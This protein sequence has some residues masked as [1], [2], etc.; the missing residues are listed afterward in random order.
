VEEVKV[1]KEEAE[2]GED[3]RVVVG[4]QAETT[5]LAVDDDSQATTEVV[6]WAV[7]EKAVVV[8]TVPPRAVAEAKVED[9]MAA[10]MA[11]AATAEEVAGTVVAARAKVAV[12][13]GAEAVEAR[14]VTMWVVTEKAATGLVQWYGRR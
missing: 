12:A 13:A 9:S 5:A 2:A 14:E 6:Q 7:A 3:T 4:E 11:T 10:V 1:K 8:A